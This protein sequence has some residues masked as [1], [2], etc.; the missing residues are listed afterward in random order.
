V[1]GYPNLLIW[2]IDFVLDGGGDSPTERRR[3][4]LGGGAMAQFIGDGYTAAPVGFP[5]L[6]LLLR[7]W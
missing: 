2:T 3:R 6:G 7:G 1:K 5:H 4:E